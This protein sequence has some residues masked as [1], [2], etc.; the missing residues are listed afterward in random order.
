MLNGIS[1]TPARQPPHSSV[2]DQV[3]GQSFSGTV[4]S[5]MWLEPQDRISILEFTAGATI[6]ASVAFPITPWTFRKGYIHGADMF[7]AIEYLVREVSGARFPDIGLKMVEFFQP[8][9]GQL[10]ISVR[11]L[12]SSTNLPVNSLLTAFKAVISTRGHEAAD[13]LWLAIGSFNGKPITDTES[14]NPLIRR[15]F[16]SQPNQIGSAWSNQE[17]ARF[18]LNPLTGQGEQQLAEMPGI[19]SATVLDMLSHALLK[20]RGGILPETEGILIKKV[21][22]HSDINQRR[23]IEE[24]R[25]LTL[26][27]TAP[28]NGDSRSFRN[29]QISATIR[30]GNDDPLIVLTAEVATAK[31]DADLERFIGRTRSRVSNALSVIANEASRDGKDS[32][33]ILGEDRGLRTS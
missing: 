6:D 5:S 15:I 29:F 33:G 2:S 21:E 19:R 7:P 25:S 11:P 23:W 3:S 31:T 8:A 12:S 27:V 17:S 30:D 4:Q 10:D 13:N 28:P 16:E 1:F 14:R 32:C 22:C 18:V 24:C 9:V 20:I 26:N